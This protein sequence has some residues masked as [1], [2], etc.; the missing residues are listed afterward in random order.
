MANVSNKS[1]ETEINSNI[2]INRE[3]FVIIL[4]NGYDTKLFKNK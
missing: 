4:R 3:Y 2:S 1:E